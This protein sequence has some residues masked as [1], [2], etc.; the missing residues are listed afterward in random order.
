[1]LHTI[2][3]EQAL[4]DGVAARRR[5]SDLRQLELELS[6]CRVAMWGTDPTLQASF[7]SA[8]DYESFERTHKG[9]G[10]SMLAAAD[11]QRASAGRELDIEIARRET[12]A[13]DAA[14]F[15]RLPVKT[16][17]RFGRVEAF[18]AFSAFERSE[19]ARA[20]RAAK[21]AAPARR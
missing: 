6:G 10:L 4:A 7:P 12:R 17:R 2:T 21:T 11:R 13:E 15:E 8:W 14:R 5:A 19:R 18:V 3:R 9:G 20:E 16:Q 1:M